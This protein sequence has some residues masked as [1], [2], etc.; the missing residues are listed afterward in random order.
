M[1]DVALIGGTGVYQADI[2]EDPEERE[3][4]TP[5]GR[6]QLWIGNLKGKKREAIFVTRHGRGHALPPHRVPYRAILWA[7]KSMGVERVAATAA[8]GSLRE[9]LPPGTLLLPHSFLDFTRQRPS[10]FYDGGPEGVVHVDMTEPYCPV[11]RQTAAR[12][13]KERGLRVVEGGI[14]ACT[15]GPR[16]ETPAEIRMLA[17]WG[18]DVVGM[19]GVPEVVLA[20]ELGLC[21]MTV[22]LVTNYAA[23]IKPAP[24]TQEE[25]LDAMAGWKGMLAPFLRDVLAEL[26]K[27]REGC[28]CAKVPSPMAVLVGQGEGEADAK[29]R[30]IFR[31]VTLLDGTGGVE[32]GVSVV[33]EG[34]EVKAVLSSGEPLPRGRTI[35]GEGK[36]LLP[37]LINLH[38]HAAM[39][40]FRTFADD[41]NLMDWLQTKIWPAEARLTGEDVYWGTLHSIVEMLK[42]GTTTFVDM[43]FFEE[44][45]ARAVLESGMRAVL[46]R[47]LVATDPKAGEKALQEGV[48]L[49]RRY[50]GAGDGRIRTMLGPHAPYTCPPEFL[51]EVFAASRELKVPI[52]I[53]LHETQ[54]EV[55]TYRQRYG[56]SPIQMMAR[57]GLWDRPLL[58]AHCVWVDDEDMELLAALPGGGVAHNPLSNLKLGSG[59]APL[60][61]LLR[62]GVRVGLGTDGPTSTNMLSLFEEMRL[63]AWLAKGRERDGSLLTA[64]EAFR[65]GTS[66]GGEILQW[67]GLGQVR[68]GGPADLVLL[69]PD[70]P[71]FTPVFD[72]HA[73]VVWGAQDADVDTVMVAGKILMEKGRLLTLDEE[74]IAFEVKSRS[75]RLVEGL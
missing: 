70:S 37:G 71:R 5:Y 30:V 72:W 24:L 62:R 46:S 1:T 40:L 50:E 69:S 61:D 51:R 12:L 35:P 22:A 45:V 63:A 38:Q 74:R 13:A 67:E 18:G 44:E 7:L 65:L 49:C 60:K 59:I 4:I 34:G 43:Y 14:Y 21:Y 19:T 15:E 55:E 42:S 23:G 47:G 54:G 29:D 68:P 10:T 3:L 6:V 58:A 31:G 2:L 56:A 33:V 57:W 26:P 27:E 20:R 64:R 28:A 11:M 32:E 36:V 16:F 17:Q 53:H 52:H 25:V 8:V 66:A 48:D 41:M 73:A 9:H 39:S 75:R